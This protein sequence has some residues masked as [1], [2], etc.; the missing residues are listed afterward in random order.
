M[1]K[2]LSKTAPAGNVLIL[3]HICTFSIAIALLMSITGCQNDPVTSP[4]T[5]SGNSAKN[6]HSAL[7]NYAQVNLVSDVDEYKAQII[8]QNLVNAWGI[9]FGPTGGIWVSAND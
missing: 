8:D 2:N 3:K 9:A 6:V 4:S 5:N 7:A 1:E